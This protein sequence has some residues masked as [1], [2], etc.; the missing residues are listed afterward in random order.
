M[1]KG[2]FRTSQKTITNAP[3]TPKIV[4]AKIPSSQKVELIK[5]PNEKLIEFLEE[6]GLNWQA[7]SLRKD[8]TSLYFSFNKI[9]EAGARE[10]ARV[11]KDNSTLTSLNLEDNK[12][13]KSILQTIGE[14]LKRNQAIA[15]KKAESLNAAGDDLYNQE[16]YSE[17]IEKYESAIKI[18]K[19]LESYKYNKEN[20][21]EK[22]KEK[23]EK[24]YEEQQKQ[25]VILPKNNCQKE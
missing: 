1:F 10:I 9:G 24:K 25:M 14:C 12:I 6:R 18:K 20:L 5:T 3:S 21:Y 8:A 4:Q 15:E 7:D 13:G 16:K 23:A 19:E 2:Q 11:L 17:A 22:N